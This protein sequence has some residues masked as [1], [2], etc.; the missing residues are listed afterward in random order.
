[1]QRIGE[2]LRLANQLLEHARRTERVSN[3]EQCNSDLVY[4]LYSEL[5][6]G[7]LPVKPVGTLCI[8]I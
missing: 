6:N 8:V 5:F 4:L 3:L 1:M 2:L 7:Q